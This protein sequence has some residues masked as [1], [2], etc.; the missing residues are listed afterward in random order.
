MMVTLYNLSRTWNTCTYRLNKCSGISVKNGQV[1]F[2][3]NQV[4]PSE[5]RIIED[6][7][8]L[9][10][11]SK[12]ENLFTKANLLQNYFKIYNKK[13]PGKEPFE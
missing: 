13:A 9:I 4:R 3:R 7:C 1:S 5:M 12:L 11:S 8:R 6:V 2:S 10:Y